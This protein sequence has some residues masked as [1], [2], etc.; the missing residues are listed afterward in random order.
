M[1]ILVVDD[2][3]LLVKGIKFNL[4]NII[5]RMER[6]SSESGLASLKESIPVIQATIEEVRRISMDLRPSILDDLGILATISWFCRE[7][8]SVYTRITINR[9]I[10]LEEEDVPEHLKIIIFR[11]IQEALNNVVRH[12]EA[13]EVRL[14]IRVEGEDADRVAARRRLPALLPF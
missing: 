9:T 11:I 8:Q 6:G 13:S 5:G 1:K 4:E 7:F 10:S 3:K 14:R 2:E 12:A